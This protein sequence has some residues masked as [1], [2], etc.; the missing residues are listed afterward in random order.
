MRKRCSCG[1][2][3]PIWRGYHD[4]RGVE[5]LYCTKCGRR[6]ALRGWMRWVGRIRPDREGE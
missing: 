5:R 6:V 1:Y 4:G 2:R 3:R